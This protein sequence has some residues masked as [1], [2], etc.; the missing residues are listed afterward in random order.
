MRKTMNSQQKSYHAFIESVCTELG[1]KELARPLQE[2][3]SALCE[4]MTPGNLDLVRYFRDLDI[5]GDRN[6]VPKGFRDEETFWEPR[7]HFDRWIVHNSQAADRIYEEGFRY[8]MKIGRLAN[9][10]GSYSSNPREKI[11]GTVAFGT[12]LE[13]AKPLEDDC[14]W[15]SDW[16]DC[17]GSIV[18]KVSGVTAY[19]RDDKD[20][21][22]MFDIRSPEG[23]FWIRNTG[24]KSRYIDPFHIEHDSDDTGIPDSYEVIGKDPDRPLCTGTYDR[25]IRWCRDNGDA[26]AHMMK[27]WK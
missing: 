22:V 16:I 20:E 4:G 11:S 1:C 21:Q 17:G 15:G 24:F 10:W 13:D 27:R 3:L 2:G 25:C 7:P 14:L 19:H 6:D 18:C 26:Y 8:G 12:P 5:E 9:S 23:C